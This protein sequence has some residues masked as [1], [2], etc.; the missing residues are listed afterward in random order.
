[1]QEVQEYLLSKGIRPSPQRVAIM[2]YLQ[3]HCTHPTVDEVFAALHTIMPTLSKTT[4]YNTLKLFEEKRAIQVINIDEKNVH[5]DSIMEPH[6]HFQ[7]VRC[8]KIFDVPFENK[9]VTVNLV[10]SDALKDFEVL[11]EQI[12]YKG[13]CPHCQHNQ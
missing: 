3:E 2:G 7:C 5:L 12:H 4:I 9:D 1:M 10:K 8:G 6:A 11:Q 13:I